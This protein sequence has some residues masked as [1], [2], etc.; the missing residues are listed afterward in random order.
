[1][2]WRPHAPFRNNKAYL[3]LV[4]DMKRRIRRELEANIK[5]A[6]TPWRHQ[7]AFRLA[8]SRSV[9][10]VPPTC[11]FCGVA[12]MPVMGMCERCGGPTQHTIHVRSNQATARIPA[13]PPAPR[14]LWLRR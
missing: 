12:S 13:P 6:M 5:E 2:D 7:P 11:R 8:S 9:A 3:A 14:P 10:T 4:G 1:M